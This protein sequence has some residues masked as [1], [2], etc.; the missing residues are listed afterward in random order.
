M[1]WKMAYMMVDFI[2]CLDRSVPS[3]GQI[4]LYGKIFRNK[5]NI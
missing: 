3:Y 4:L 5:F 2:Y 1:T